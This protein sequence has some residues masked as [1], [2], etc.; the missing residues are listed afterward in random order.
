MPISEAD[1]MRYYRRAKI[2]RLKRG[3]LFEFTFWP[4]RPFWPFGFKFFGL[5]N[6]DEIF[7][8]PMC[9]IQLFR[10]SITVWKYR[11]NICFHISVIIRTLHISVRYKP[12]AKI[13]EILHIWIDICLNRHILIDICKISIILAKWAYIDRYM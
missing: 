6:F 5:R 11:Q 4:L 12:R 1:A 3:L 9:L 2:L 10:Y 13:I 7:S 8:V